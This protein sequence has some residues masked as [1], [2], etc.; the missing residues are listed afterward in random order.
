MH[1]N[2]PEMK[3]YF[4]LMQPKT[5]AFIKRILKDYLNMHKIYWACTSVN[6][7]AFG[8]SQFSVR[9]SEIVEAESTNQSLL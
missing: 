8:T 1:P 3:I 7:R 4:R 5:K 9:T 6:V 2:K